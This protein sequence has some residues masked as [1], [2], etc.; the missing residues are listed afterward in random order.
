MT[1]KCRELF[2][3]AG[4]PGWALFAEVC[5]DSVAEA[6]HAASDAA[7][8]DEDARRILDIVLADGIITKAEVYKLREVRRYVARSAAL[9]HHLAGEVLA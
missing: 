8:A 6:Q 5:S 1:S 4:H 2:C 9:D 3:R 7:T